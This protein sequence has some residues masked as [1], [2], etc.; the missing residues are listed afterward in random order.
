MAWRGCRTLFLACLTMLLCGGASFLAGSAAATSGGDNGKIVYTGS[1]PPRPNN[2]DGYF[3]HTINSDGTGTST[4]AD[5]CNSYN[6]CENSLYW[7]SFSPDGTKIVWSVGPGAF[8]RTMDADDADGST[9]TSLANGTNQY[10]NPTTIVS[11]GSSVGAYFPAWSPDGTK[12]AFGGCKDGGGGCSIYTMSSSGPSDPSTVQPI[13]NTSDAYNSAFAWSPDGSEIAYPAQDPS[14]SRT[15]DGISY[16]DQL[17]VAVNVN[18]GAKREITDI[19]GVPSDSW[20]IDSNPD[21]SPDGS[22]IVFERMLLVSSSGSQNSTLPELWITNSAGTLARQLTTDERFQRDDPSFSPDCTKIAFERYT[23]TTADDI[24]VANVDGSGESPL[25]SD[26]YVEAMPSWQP[27]PRAEAVTCAPIQAPVTPAAPSGV[28]AAAGDGTASVS[29]V[30]P[31]NGG[32]LIE[33]YTIS[34]SDGASLVVSGTKH[35]AT[36][37]N[38]DNGTAYTFAVSATNSVG[39]G[40]TSTQSNEVTPT[41]GASSPQT[42][43]GDVAPGGT[44]A[45]DGGYS[46]SVPVGVSLQTPTGGTIA[47][48]SSDA[49]APAPTGFQFFGR[50]VDITAPAASVDAPVSLYFTVD[51]SVLGA[52][53]PDSVQVFRDGSPVADPCTGSGRADPDPCIV[54]RYPTGNGGVSIQILTSHASR[55]NFGAEEHDTTPPHL[56]CGSADRAWHNNNVSIACA[57]SDAESGLADPADANFALATAVAAGSETA[58]AQTGTHAV[59]DKAANCSTAGPIAGN[60][61]DRKPPQITLTTPAAGA[62]YTYRQP[63]TAA[64]ACVDG[65]SGIR[66]PGFCTGTPMSGSNVGTTTPGA[67]TFTVTSQD[68]VANA[69][70]AVSHTY[71]VRFA[72]GGFYSP[73][74]NQP[75]YIN[76][77]QSGKGVPV[78]FSLR[79]YSGSSIYGSFGLAIFTGTGPTSAAITCPATATKNTISQT[80]TLTGLRYISSSAQ[81]EYDWPTSASWKGTCRAL[82]LKFKDGTPQTVYF[83]FK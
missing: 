30:A 42:V 55:W 40:P 15:I 82:T 14:A 5:A 51:G 19:S 21:W 50:Q 36:I 66:A 4:L 80:T 32:E 1:Q 38:L 6:I 31:D 27:L 54:A 64:F 28:I 72:F 2:Q 78:P 63:V 33:S 53:S 57:A 24:A 9:I 68:A 41:A 48:V 22:Q 77:V 81:Y 56:S 75:T 52:T 60:M 71:S 7:P 76:V 65:G 70:T 35:T 45:L 13:P 18:T 46:A 43:T 47:I 49:T 67:N 69:A 83:Q 37:S 39:T 12:I 34:V 26:P 11:D 23:P 58:N 3:L 8:L 16:S 20:A 73:L 25:M 17:I 61:I 62:V 10:G 59:C 79:D 29:W 74:K 44:V